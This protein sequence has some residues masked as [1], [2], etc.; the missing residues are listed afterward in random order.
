MGVRE[1][2]FVGRLKSTECHVYLNGQQYFIE[3]V[4]DISRKAT[5]VEGRGDINSVLSQR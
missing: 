5:A 1:C 2:E 3:D 4:P